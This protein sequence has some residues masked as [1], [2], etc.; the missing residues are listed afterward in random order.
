MFKNYYQLLKFDII[1]EVNGNIS[2][3]NDIYISDLMIQALF[4]ENY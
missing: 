1:Y 4:G 3:T 2:W